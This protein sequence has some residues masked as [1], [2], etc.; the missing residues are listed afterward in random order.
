MAEEEKKEAVPEVKIK[1]NKEW[2]KVAKKTLLNEEARL[3]A[4]GDP[5]QLKLDA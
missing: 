1:K 3:R 5:H 2:D 4:I